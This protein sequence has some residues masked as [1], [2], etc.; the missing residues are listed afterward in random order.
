MGDTVTKFFEP[1]TFQGSN[2]E[3]KDKQTLVKWHFENN[4]G[5]TPFKTFSTLYN[6]EGSPYQDL[7]LEL[8]L[9]WPAEESGLDKF[10]EELD[11]EQANALLERFKKK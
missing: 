2:G 10:F 5:E 4:M 1:P 7:F 6:K 3:L 9:D 11:L 8:G